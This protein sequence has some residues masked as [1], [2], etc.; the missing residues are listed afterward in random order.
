MNTITEAEKQFAA[1]E[2][3]KMMRAAAYANLSFFLERES[4]LKWKPAKHLELLCD[5]LQRVSK[6]DLKRVIVTMPPRH[7]KS[8]VVSK[9]FPAWHLGRNPNDEIILASYSIDLSRSFSR[10]ARETLQGSSDVFS[11]RLDPNHSTAESW[12]LQGK[13]GGL[14]AAGVGGSI[15][16]RGARIAIVDD[17][18]KNAE[19]ANSE[20][21]RSKVW[22][23]YTSTLYTRLT[24]K[25][26][27]VIVMTR[28]HEDDLVGRLLQKE[29]Q[30]IEEGSHIGDRWTV[31]NLPAL[32][33]QNDILGRLE[34]DPLW[35]EYGFDQER[36]QQIKRDVGS[37]VFNSLYQQRPAAQEGSMF[38]RQ[39]WRFYDVLPIRFDEMMQS[40]DMSFKGS[41]GS[42]FVVGQVWGRV[43]A[44]KYLVDQIRGRMDISK[45]IEHIQRLTIKYPL[46]R[47]KLIEDKANGPAVISLLKNSI[48]GL[49]AV[50]PDGGKVSRASAIIP[51]VEAGN[52][53]L[54]RNVGWIDDFIQEC[55]SF[56]RG[57][58][59]DQ[60]DAMTQAIRR[61]MFSD[62]LGAIDPYAVKISDKHLHFALQ[63]DAE[64]TNDWY[65]M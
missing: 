28:W 3:P 26:A 35:S 37:Y 44:N 40:W 7:G 55:N 42:D 16:G 63:D 43:G 22:E 46:A 57:A 27:V 5:T 38:K 49:V 33:E 36:L 61:M 51:D 1:T 48:S 18:I 34:G 19:E 9:K 58:H 54:P 31:I 21:I 20:V 6:G 59:D 10:I 25:G 15:T 56:P 14:V 64:Q 12:G 32:A 41:D 29:R 45:T 53:Y 65:V 39:W 47:L 24:P 60:V 23:W 17:P 11:V 13:R 2:I 62:G 4:R 30:E 50:N 52:V 8:E